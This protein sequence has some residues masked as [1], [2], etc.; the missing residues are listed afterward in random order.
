MFQL[1]GHGDG[2]LSGIGNL[3]AAAED[4]EL[5]GGRQGVVGAIQSHKKVDGITAGVSVAAH[6]R[7]E[8]RIL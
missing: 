2:A 8:I 5:E 1:P 3:R 6:A 4:E 7:P